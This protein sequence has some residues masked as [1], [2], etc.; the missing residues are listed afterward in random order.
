MA[1][2]QRN[3]R[4]LQAN[5]GT[6]HVTESYRSERDEAVIDR[7]EVRPALVPREGRRSAGYR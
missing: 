6:Y 7:V 3:A 5:L 2:A 1:H 4:L